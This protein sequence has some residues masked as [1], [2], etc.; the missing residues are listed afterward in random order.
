MPLNATDAERQATA[1]A[2]LAAKIRL[3]PPMERE[4]RSWFTQ[5][6]KDLEAFYATTGQVPDAEIYLPELMGILNRQYRR[7][8]SEFSGSITDFLREADEDDPTVMI[9]TGFA[10]DNGMSFAEL[11]DTMENQVTVAEQEFFVTNATQDA[12]NITSTTQKDLDVSIIFGTLFLI[13]QG[14]PNPSRNQVAKQSRKEFT[15]MSRS[16]PATIATTVTQ[17][18]AEGVKQIENDVFFA[19][20]NRGAAIPLRKQEFWITRGDEV[21]REAHVIAD[22][23]EK[24]LNGVFVVGGEQLKFPG[25]TSLGASA[26]NVINCRCSSVLV[27]DDS[28]TPIIEQVA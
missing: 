2:D 4:L 12:A 10:A 20:R 24:N 5:I 9:L 28:Q 26:K 18:A 11:V 23:Q 16:R 8:D 1:N 7:V 17:K 19:N 27:I 13:D 6:S 21:V 25:D 22:N 15:R 14:I 3:E